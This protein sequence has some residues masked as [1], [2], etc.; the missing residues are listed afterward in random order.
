MTPCARLLRLGLLAGAI[1]LATFG[2]VAADY[3]VGGAARSATPASVDWAWDGAYIAPFRGALENPANFGPAG[4]V[5]RSIS[6]VDLTTIDATA[7]S[8]LSMFVATWIQDDNLSTGQVGAIRSFFLGGGDL[9]LL[10]DDS[11]HDVV[12]EALGLVTSGSTGSV[13]NG[14]APLYDGP[15][16][17]ARD[18][19]QLYNVGQLDAAA[20]A[21]FAGTV[22]GR[23]AEGQ[24]TSAYWKRGQYAPGAGALFINADI[25]MIASTPGRCGAPD[26]GAL[27]SPLNDNGVFALNTFA[28]IQR[29][30]GNP[31][32]IPEPSSYALMLIGL[33]LL[34]VTA[35]RRVTGAPEATG[36]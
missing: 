19:A 13:S 18:V 3:V 27:Y 16:G 15:F 7:L 17:L 26:C 29:E 24:V 25:D 35:R 12:G 31:P 28:F 21:S 8:S 36:A 22:A 9:F 34:W 6:T 11:A 30:G 23:N 4:I 32:A 10:Q 14:G 1:A 33:G 5:N 2:A 20:V